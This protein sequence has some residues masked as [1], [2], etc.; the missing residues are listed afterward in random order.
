MAQ[1]GFADAVVWNI[2]P[3]KAAGLTDLGAGEWERYVC[4]EAAQL[5]PTVVSPGGR[6][7]GGQ[8]LV[9]PPRA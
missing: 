8:L 9:A 6:W 7:S 4:V 1:T 5:R 2:G 3:E